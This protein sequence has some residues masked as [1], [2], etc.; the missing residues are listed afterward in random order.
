MASK[1]YQLRVAEVSK[2]TVEAVSVTFEVPSELKEIFAFKHGQ[3]LTVKVSINGKEVRRAYSI[4]SSPLDNKL[5]IGVKK[6]ANGSVSVYMNEKLKA[7]DLLEVMPP[8]GNFTCELHL[9]NTKEYV[10][11]GAGSGI[12]PLISIIKTILHTE[13]N[14]NVHLIYSNRTNETIM[15]KNE[16]EILVADFPSRFKLTHVLSKDMQWNGFKGRINSK[17]ADEY[18]SKNLNSSVKNAEYF[19]CGPKPM[20]DELRDF[21]ESK[22]VSKTQIHRE[23]FTNKISESEAIKEDIAESIDA[24]GIL[25]TREI[26]IILYGEEH[27]IMVEPDETVLTAAMTKGIDPPFSCQIGACST[28]R[29]R[30]KSGKVDMESRDALMDSEIEDGFILTC[31]SHPMSDDV[32]IDYDDNF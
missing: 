4:S 7:G 29:A 26:T 3:Y 30:L 12:T 27:H 19:L 21:F 11:F 13:A 18:L 6:V 16:L 8:M 20:M 31:T 28:C 1:F 22:G 5:R 32:V 24:D 15:Y 14:S 25:K 2:E 17:L 23:V 10:F 9:S